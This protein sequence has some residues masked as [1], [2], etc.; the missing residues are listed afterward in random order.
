MSHGHQAQGRACDLGPERSPAVS[1]QRL[2]TRDTRLAAIVVSPTALPA[3][4]TTTAAAHDR[5][6][7]CQPTA[8]RGLVNGPSA[9]LTPAA[10]L[11]PVVLSP[12]QQCPIARLPCF[13]ATR[14]V[15]PGR[16]PGSSDIECQRTRL[17][18]VPTGQPDYLQLQP[19]HRHK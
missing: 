13:A 1:L 18:P 19:H 9:Q 6:S 2:H 11:H 15:Y 16:R 7:L 17:V 10:E 8:A 4:A 3:A 5:H 12:E 14:Q